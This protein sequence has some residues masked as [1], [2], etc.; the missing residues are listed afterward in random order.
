MNKMNALQTETFELMKQ[1]DLLCTKHGIKYTLGYGTLLGAIRHHGFIPWDDDV[2]ILMDYCNYEKF[3][4][5]ISEYDDVMILLDNTT[6]PTYYCATPKV[7]L[8]GSKYV[9]YSHSH[10]GETDGVWIDIFRYVPIDNES[11]ALEFGKK[12]DALNKKISYSVY[13][14]AMPNDTFVRKFLKS[15]YFGLVSNNYKINPFLKRYLN[16]R[17][18]LIDEVFC[19]YKNSTATEYYTFDF[20]F[21]SEDYFIK[22]SLTSE[23]LSNITRHIFEGASFPIPQNYDQVLRKVYG[24]YMELPKLEDRETH[25]VEMR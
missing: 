17:N 11:D 23:S 16:E 7:K 1:F 3:K 24:D 15:V 2:D 5:V 10:L 6:S 19:K 21:N 18:E 9:E 12:I 13:I 20:F 8:L 25:F 22:H 14:K 4:R